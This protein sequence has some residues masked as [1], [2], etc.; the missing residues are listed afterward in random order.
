MKTLKL[1]GLFIALMCFAVVGPLAAQE[2]TVTQPA[3][4][5]DAAEP[6]AEATQVLLPGTW[7][8]NGLRYEPQKW[9][10]CGPATITNALSYFGYADNQDRAASFLKPN[11]E[12]KNVSP[13]Q[14]VYFVNNQV[15]EIPVFALER[16]GG[17]LDTIKLL[18]FNNFP[19]IIEAGYDPEPDRLGWMGHYLLVSGYD[20]L[21]R[22]IYTYDSYIGPDTTYDY[23]YIQEFWQH[24][25]YTYIVVYE[26]GREPELL[27]LLGS[28]ADI[29][30]NTISAL[31]KAR[32]EAV[33]D[34]TN[35]WAWFNMGTNFTNLGMYEEGAAAYDHAFNLGMPFRTLWYQFGPFEAYYHIG[36]YDKVITYA[37][38][39]LNDG[40]GHFV[41]ETFYYGGL[42]REALGETDRALN[43]YL[44]AARFNPNFT[45]AVE[46]RDRLQA[47]I[48]G[49]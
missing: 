22:V 26:S 10:N 14:M 2:T 5:T 1:W 17:T 39:N 11:G 4:A 9:N 47:Q 45:L 16:V 46:A 42:A 20:D 15:P 49:S 40:G 34:Q 6:T 13:N 21:Q 38:A 29:R 28:D 25:N 7:R 12:D 35:K 24:F 19:V 41:E 37:Q 18:L 31:E 30:Q 3:P 44:E 36:A 32:E 48:N 33:A 43:N 8:L 27:N 23:D